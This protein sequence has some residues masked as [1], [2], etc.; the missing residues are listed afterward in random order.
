MVRINFVCGNFRQQNR[1]KV[2]S[3][4]VVYI[5]NHWQR[6]TQ[7]ISVQRCVSPGSVTLHR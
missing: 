5:G 2:C 3:F 1:R 6:W 7:M 4:P